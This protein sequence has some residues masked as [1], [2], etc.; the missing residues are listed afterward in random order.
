MSGTPKSRATGWKRGP[1]DDGGEEHEDRAAAGRR[2]VYWQSQLTSAW[3][4]NRFRASSDNLRP[5]SRCQRARTCDGLI[6]SAV[7]TEPDPIVDQQ[8][9]AGVRSDSVP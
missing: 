9:P 2:A 5:V 3:A 6:E 8:D 1:V 4:K 7:S